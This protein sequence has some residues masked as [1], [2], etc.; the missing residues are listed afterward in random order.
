LAQPHPP[1]FHPYPAEVGIMAAPLR[2]TREARRDVILE[3]RRS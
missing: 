1:P 3:K 2:M